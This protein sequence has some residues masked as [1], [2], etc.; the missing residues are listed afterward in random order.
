MK[1]GTQKNRSKKM[2]WGTQKRHL[3]KKHQFY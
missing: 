3:S 2:K 1:Q